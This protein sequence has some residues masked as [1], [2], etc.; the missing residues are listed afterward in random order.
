MNTKPDADAVERYRRGGGEGPCYGK[1]DVALADTEAAAA[2]PGARDLA[3][4]RA[5]RRTRPGAVAAGPLRGRD[6]AGQ[7]GRRRGV[8][9]VRSGPAGPHR[10]PPRVRRGRLRP[11]RGAAGRQSTRTASSIMYAESVL[12]SLRSDRVA[13]RDQADA[14]QS[15][16]RWPLRA[17]VEGTIRWRVA[18]PRSRRRRGSSVRER[19]TRHVWSTSICPYCAVGCGQKVYVKD[20]AD[21]PDRGRSRQPD[22]ARPPLP[23]GLGVEEPGHQQAAPVPGQVSP[24]VRRP[25]GRSLGLDEAMDMIA[26]RVIETRRRTWQQTRRR[27]TARLRRSLGVVNLGGATLGQRGEL[28]DQE[29]DDRARLRPGRKP[30]PHMT[31][32]HRP[33]SG[34]VVRTRRGDHVPAGSA[35][36]RLHPDHGLEHGR[37]PSG[38]LPVGDGGEAQRGAR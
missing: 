12:P 33:R 18:V 21:H 2:R 28:H 37:V 25:T 29:A 22:L 11:R 9:P 38:R 17:A 36:R 23:E 31:L 24:A 35:E 4:Q 20:G 8:D 3:H 5:W 13:A 34:D 32:L 6:G 15:V 30:G 7:R 19:R 10:P 14:L 1:M 16:G 26:D 27:R